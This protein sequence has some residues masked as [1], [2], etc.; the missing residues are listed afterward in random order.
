MLV[1]GAYASAHDVAMK[2]RDKMPRDPNER[3]KAVADNVDSIL[4]TANLS[5]RQRKDPAR[6]REARSV[7]RRAESSGQYG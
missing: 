2:K 4:A 7:K 5:L 3:A 6:V 1:E